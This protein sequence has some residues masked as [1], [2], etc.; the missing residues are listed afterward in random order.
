MFKLNW[1]NCLLWAVS[2]RL[3]VL[4]A[5]DL[6]DHYLYPLQFTDID[7]HVFSDAALLISQGKSPYQVPTYRYPPVVAWLLVSNQY[8]H[9]CCGKVIFAIFDTLWVREVILL[10]SS[11]R[12]NIAASSLP[13]NWICALNPISIYICCRGSSDA[14]SNYFILLCLRMLLSSQILIAGGVLGF[15]IY[16]RVYPIIYLPAFALYLLFQPNKTLFSNLSNVVKLIA[17]VIMSA[18]M[19]T[20]VSYLAYGQEYLGQAIL[21]HFQREDHRHNFSIHYLSIYFKKSQAMMFE[22]CGNKQC[23]DVNHDDF[24]VIAFLIK[25]LPLLCQACLMLIVIF[26]YALKNLAKCMLLQTMIFVAFNK[27]ITG[28]YFLWYFAL[29][30]LVCHDILTRYKDY[31]LTSIIWIFA[32]CLWLLQAYRLEFLGQNTFIEIYF[33]SIIFLFANIYC[34]HTVAKC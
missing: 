4:L 1:S 28:Q 24:N 27:V 17:A 34:I 16:L 8:L 7:Y 31:I 2:I 3:I 22:E 15:V 10:S 20:L 23:D 29:V 19:W 26:I 18:G 6:I 13:W 30:P 12:G 33:A 25:L 9:H 5:G 14:I 21:Y 11:I 32:L